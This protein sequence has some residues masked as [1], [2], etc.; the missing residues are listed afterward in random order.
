MSGEFDPRKTKFNIIQAKTSKMSFNPDQTKPTH[1]VIFSR[2]TKNIIYP[3]LYFNNVPIVKTTSQKH[4][5][6]K[7]D[8]RLSF[9][10]HLNKKNGKTMKGADL[11]KLQC[12]LLHSSLL[13]INHSE[14]HIWTME[15]YI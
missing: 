1:E 15:C 7:L 4:L 9:N 11:H 14:D 13:F 12:L 2:K 3:N 5:E 10:D 6:H 8:L